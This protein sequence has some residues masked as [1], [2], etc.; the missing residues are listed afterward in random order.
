MFRRKDFKKFSPRR[1]SY[2]VVGEIAANGHLHILQYLKEELHFTFGFNGFCIPTIEN[3]QIEILEWLSS[4]NCLDHH[5]EN[6][7]LKY[8]VRS[9][10]IDV[11]ETFLRL[12]YE[13]IGKYT[14]T[15]SMNDAILSKSVDMMNYCLENGA[16]FDND[17]SNAI[18]KTRSIEVYRFCHEKG[19]TFRSTTNIFNGD[20]L[21]QI[22]HSQLEIIKF[23]RS[24]LIP[25]P[26]DM[27]EDL[28]TSCSLEIIQFVHQNG[29]PWT[30]YH[31]VT[32]SDYL[33]LLRKTRFTV[34]RL[35]EKLAY[36]VENGC[37]LN[38]FLEDVSKDYISSEVFG[39]FYETRN[40]DVIK[41]FVGK[42]SNFD[43]RLLKE[44]LH[45]S[46]SHYMTLHHYMSLH[47]ISQHKILRNQRKTEPLW[48]DGVKYIYE[49]GKDISSYSSIEEIFE[50]CPDIVLIKY[51]RQS[52]GLRWTRSEDRNNTFLSRFACYFESNDVDWAWTNGCKGGSSVPF[53]IDEWK[54]IGI[55]RTSKWY[56]NFKFLAGNR[57]LDFNI[58]RIGDELFNGI[59]KHYQDMHF[60]S[61][62][63]C[64]LLERGFQY[65]T[66]SQKMEVC[67]NAYEK[68]IISTKYQPIHIVEERKVLALLQKLRV[69]EHLSENR[70]EIDEQETILPTPLWP[71]EPVLSVDHYRR[72][73]RLEDE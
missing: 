52:I 68:C 20:S 61:D 8:A 7:L 73:R 2:G 3:G 69:T 33:S 55:R 23:L 14:P 44:V 24:V 31:H 32:S 34:D 54:N 47:H 18:A 5:R 64:F 17:S 28:L 25:W 42:N 70:K 67:K 9:G 6:M 48:L 15:F 43:N 21:E 35:K 45:A 29:C 46:N 63:L 41:V 51:L 4:I 11:L 49:N 39:N 1:K 36:L 30:D 37:P 62:L 26:H 40:L 56:E 65:R 57:I 53:L 59:E 72:S 58:E 10:R 60:D 16:Q 12:D 13:R 38:S 19:F 22:P 66:L 50:I 71:V 27:M